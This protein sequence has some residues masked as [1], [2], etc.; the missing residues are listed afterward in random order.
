M[1]ITEDTQDEDP[2]DLDAVWFWAL[3]DPPG[4]EE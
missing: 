2:A 4:N 1:F 3:H